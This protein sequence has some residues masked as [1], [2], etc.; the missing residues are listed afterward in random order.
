VIVLTLGLAIAANAIVFGFTA[1]L[2]LRPLPIANTDRLVTIYG[3]DHLLGQDRRRASIPDYLDIKAQSTEFEDALAIL[4]GA[5]PATFRLVALN[6]TNAWNPMPP[7][8]PAGL[9]GELLERRPD[10]ATAERQ[11][12]SANARIGVAKAA[13]FPVVRL[14]G[15]GGYLSGDIDNLFNWE[16]RVWSIG[17]SVSLPIFAGGRNR[18]EYKRSKAAYQEAI[19]KFRQQILVAFGEVEDSLAGI[20]HLSNQ[21]VAQNRAVTNS[22][23][24]ADLATQRYRSGLVSYLEVVDASREALQAERG[25]AQLSGQRLVVAVQLIKALGGGWNERQLA[26]SR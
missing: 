19:A 1:L 11:L 2:L 22:R 4:V 13:F 5:N 23:R 17:P 18:A 20:H 6:G 9:P 12:A 14:T 16:S 24:A 3:V 10:V 26:P 25:S 15:S 21:A 8:I 7:A